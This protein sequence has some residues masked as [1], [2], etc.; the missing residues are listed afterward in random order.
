LDG[1]KILEIGETNSVI[2][3]YLT[4]MQGRNEGEKVLVNINAAGK[5]KPVYFTAISI[6]DNEHR[7]SSKLS[8]TEPFHVVLGYTFSSKLSGVECMLRIETYD[9]IAVFSSTHRF[10]DS[11]V[12]VSRKDVNAYRVTVPPMFLMPGSYFV[13]IAAHTPMVEV[14]DLYQQVLGFEIVDTGTPFAIHG[15]YRKIGIV[16]ANLVW[17]EVAG[18]RNFDRQVLSTAV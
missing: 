13:T 1:G 18:T 3:K 10:P 11:A 9:G 5:E 14:H 6:L 8:V 16:M 4:R 15:N 17:Q 2:A 12:C 7:I